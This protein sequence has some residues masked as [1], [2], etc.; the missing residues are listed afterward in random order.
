MWKMKISVDF[1]DDIITGLVIE[2]LKN[3]YDL[4]DED[5][6]RNAIQVV[7]EYYMIPDDW[8]KWREE[9]VKFSV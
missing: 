7:L 9:K 4:C 1:N 2:S 8:N 3:D 5:E 6:V